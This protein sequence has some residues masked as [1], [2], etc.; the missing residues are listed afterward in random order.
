M[1]NSDPAKVHADHVSAGDVEAARA[2]IAGHVMETPFL[3]ARVLSQITGAQV[4]V[5]FENLQFTASFKE[6]G[7]L[8]RISVLTD[9]ERSRGVAAMSAGNHAQGVAFHARRLSIPALIVMPRATALTK[10][11]NTRAHGAEVL[12]TGDTLAEAE[13]EALKQAQARGMTF[14]HPY[15][16]PFVIAGQGTLALEMIEQRP[17]LE[18]VVAPIGGGGLMSGMSIALRHVSPGIEIVGVQAASYPA[19]CVETGKSSAGAASSGMTTIADGIAV[20]RPGRLTSAIIRAN[21]DDILLAPEWAIE[22]AVAL[23]LNVEKTVAEGAGAAA[24][25]ALIAF[26][27]R[28]RGRRV[29]IVLSGGNIDARLLSSILMRE[30]VREQRIVTVRIPLAD[31]PGLLAGVTAAMAQAGAN[32][33]EVQ[34]RRNWL[35]LAANEATVDIVFE[36]RD[37]AHAQGVIEA[38]RACGHAPEIV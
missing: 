34:H 28:F 8:N 23:F 38:L 31:Q 30:L 14:I 12:L 27:D 37:R 19:M 22:K 32:I 18:C 20:K 5:K 16:D 10:I 2:R 3:E 1:S 26:P 21:V 35:A 36:A 17:D 15:D 24:L 13:S 11:E 25:A 29:G 33:I 4:F 7:A 9:E 6:R